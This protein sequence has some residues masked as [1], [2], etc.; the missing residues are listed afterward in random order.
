MPLRRAW[1]LFRAGQSQTL[2]RVQI[3]GPPWSS[4]SSAGGYPHARTT[5]E[6]RRG[7]DRVGS[8]GGYRPADLED[9]QECSCSVRRPMARAKI[10]AGQRSVSAMFWRHSE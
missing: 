5:P 9:W 2:M 1:D 10:H 8:R 3:L 7:P 4:H 6:Q